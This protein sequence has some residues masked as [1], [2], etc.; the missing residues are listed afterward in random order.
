MEERGTAATER[1]VRHLAETRHAS[2]RSLSQGG[3]K[4]RH[5]SIKAIEMTT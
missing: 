1:E 5:A 4:S 2:D 3:E